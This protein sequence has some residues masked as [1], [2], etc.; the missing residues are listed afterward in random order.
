[1]CLCH[2]NNGGI[3]ATVAL[4]LIELLTGVP[5]KRKICVYGRVNM[6]GFLAFGTGVMPL[7]L[8]RCFNSGAELVVLDDILLPMLRRDFPAD[9]DGL[10]QAGKEVIGLNTMWQ[11]LK[12]AYKPPALRWL[13]DRA[14]GLRFV[15]SMRR[16]PADGGRTLIQIA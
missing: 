8:V 2:Q 16:R 14:W 13:V 1:V 6:A 5:I 10:A 4:L 9:M 3:G 12:E 7:H 15:A 11:V